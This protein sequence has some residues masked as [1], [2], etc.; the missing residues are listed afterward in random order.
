MVQIILEIVPVRWINI[1]LEI[2]LERKPLILTADKTAVSSHEIAILGATFGGQTVSLASF[3]P[4]EEMQL[5]NKP[6]LNTDIVEITTVMGTKDSRIFFGRTRWLFV[7][8]MLSNG[9]ELV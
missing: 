1:V 3:S 4:Y 6:I 8:N 2:G 9:A 7:R 5:M